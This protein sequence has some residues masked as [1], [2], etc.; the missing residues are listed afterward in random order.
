MKDARILFSFAHPDDE[1]FTIGGVLASLAGQ[2]EVDTI[3]YSATL[4]DAGKCGNPPIC[5]QECLSDVR[6]QELMTAANI[7]GINHLRYDTFPDGKLNQL[8]K[9]TLA[10][11]VKELIHEFKPQI[12][13]TFPPHGISGHPDHK[14]IQKATLHAIT[15][16]EHTPVE[17]LYY[18]TVTKSCDCNVNATYA[19]TLDEIA[20]S[21]HYGADEAAMVKQALKAHKTQHL[22]VE[23]VFPTI[24]SN[25]FTKFNNVEHF[26]LA[27]HKNGY[28]IPKNVLI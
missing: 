22:S 18:V 24:H 8:S 20:V 6:K 12:V 16:D 27:W 19:N 10:D 23:R 25:E 21:I 14:E 11:R 5:K 3:L 9:N 17:A 15:S 13:V 2:Q 1:S 7:L 4:G 28:V 26:M